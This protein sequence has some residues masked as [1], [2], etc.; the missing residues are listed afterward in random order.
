MIKNTFISFQEKK[1]KAR[2]LL[3]FKYSV[4]LIRYEDLLHIWNYTEKIIYLRE[5]YEK[6]WENANDCWLIC[7][8][9][10]VRYKELINQL[11]I[12]ELKTR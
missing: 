9:N 6:F 5:V 4:S 7:Q 3:N 10:R 8:K 2:D 11:N 1:K 12:R